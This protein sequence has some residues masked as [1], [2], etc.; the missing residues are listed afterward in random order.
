MSIHLSQV[1]PGHQKDSNHKHSTAPHTLLGDHRGAQTQGCGFRLLPR[2]GNDTESFTD[3]TDE[4]IA[5]PIHLPSFPALTSIYIDF[6]YEDPS[7]RLKALLTSISSAP[8]LASV[9]IGYEQW[10]IVDSA[11]LLDE[12]AGL[13]TWLARMTEQT[14]VKGGLV[15]TLK[16]WPPEMS[17]W[18]GFLP[19]FGKAGGKIETDPGGWLSLLLGILN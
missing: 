19:E 1:V 3:T 14:T 13:D 11:P 17:V 10:D 2:H 8:A 18:N 5:F 4:K 16:Q 9:D 7:P 6:Q 12:W 15:L